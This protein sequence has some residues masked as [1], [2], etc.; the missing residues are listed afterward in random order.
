[1]KHV[2][3]MVAMGEHLPQHGPPLSPGPDCSFCLPNTCLKMNLP[4]ALKPVHAC[5]VCGEV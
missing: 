2:V 5:K 3:P 1:M 4:L